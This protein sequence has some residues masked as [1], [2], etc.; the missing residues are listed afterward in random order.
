MGK[1][2]ISATCNQMPLFH[3]FM[4]IIVIIILYVYAR[5]FNVMYTRMGIHNAQESGPPPQE[6]LY[7][8]EHMFLHMERLSHYSNVLGIF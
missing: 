6:L 7:K 2:I 3:W 5:C 4:N 8:L 1:V